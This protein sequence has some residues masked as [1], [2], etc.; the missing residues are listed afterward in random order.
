VGQLVVRG[1]NVMRGYWGRPEQTAAKLREGPIPGEKVLYTGDLF[2]MDEEGDLYFVSRT[3]DIIKCKGEKVAPK[4]LEDTLC[5]MPE[6]AE[7]GVVGVDDALDGQAIKAV[8]V[9]R[10][11]AELSAERIRRHCRAQLEAYMVPKFIEF[12]DHLPKTAS[13]KMLRRELIHPPTAHTTSAVESH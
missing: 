12:R 3:D 1:A 2:R 11:G 13:G 5:L 6:V 8:I 4:Q 10:P 9:L 7:A